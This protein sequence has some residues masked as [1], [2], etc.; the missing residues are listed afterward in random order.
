MREFNGLVTPLFALRVILLE[1]L[2][3][4]LVVK[5]T[6]KSRS[7]ISELKSRGIAIGALILLLVVVVLPF[8]AGN[9][10]FIREHRVTRFYANP[11]YFTYSAIK[12]V[13][14]QFKSE[15]SQLV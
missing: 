11:T 6:P 3:A 10:S 12:F 13:Q 9:T 4:W 1:L 2:P 7:I 5:Y 15:P 14:E 8:I